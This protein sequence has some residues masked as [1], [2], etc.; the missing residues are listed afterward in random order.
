MDIPNVI[1]LFT[2]NLKLYNHYSTFTLCIMIQVSQREQFLYHRTTGTGAYATDDLSANLT[3]SS[4][5]NLIFHF[6]QH[7]CKIWDCDQFGAKRKCGAHI[8]V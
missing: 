4:N 6:H 3:S 1:V 8:I 5:I 7:K 2:P